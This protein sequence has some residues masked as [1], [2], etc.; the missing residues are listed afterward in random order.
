[1]SEIAQPSVLSEPADEEPGEN[2]LPPPQRRPLLDR[3]AFLFVIFLAVGLV[4]FTASFLTVHVRPSS[5]LTENP[6]SIRA[7]DRIMI[8]VTRGYF[9]YFGLVAEPAPAPAN[10]IVIYRT[11]TGAHL[12]S[13]FILEKIWYTI[14]GRYSWRLSA[15]HNELVALLL[16]ALLGLLAYRLTR[17][18]GLD[19]PLAIAAGS[20]IVIVVFTFPDNLSLYWEM[21]S[22][23]TMLVFATLFMLIEERGLDERRTSRLSI[24]Q[25]VVVFL[26]T[27]SEKIAAL[28]LISSM[29]VTLFLL[30]PRRERWRRFL[31]LAVAPSFLAL[32]VYGLQ[33]S[34][35]RIRFPDVK[36]VGSTFM[37]RSGLDGESLYYGDHLDIAHRRDVARSN[38]PVN[39]PYL[40]RWTWTFFLGAASALLVV[41]AYVFGRVPRIGV[42]VLVWLT[43]TWVL[44]AAVFSQAVVIHPYLYDVLLFVPLVLA[45][46]ALMPALLESLTARTGAI[47]LVSVLAALWLSLFQMRLYALRYPMPGT[48]VGSPPV[49]AQLHHPDS[50]PSPRLGMTAC[51]HVSGQLPARRRMK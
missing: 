39:R 33:L 12:V 29:A 35:A 21:S 6:G 49:A 4:V 19:P 44:Y 18:A 15:V 50:S 48:T 47:L 30:Q 25:G 3:T 46:F 42:E 37:F 1:M 16:S 38:W 20:S 7:H 17:R 27:Y 45:L 41:A 14:F 5:L 36:M 2:L 51:L 11:S 23:A 32:A 43:G 8:W 40:F 10:E 31:L 26:M 22:Q 28:A 13:T 9:H 34:A 24:F